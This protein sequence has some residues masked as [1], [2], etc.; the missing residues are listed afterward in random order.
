MKFSDLRWIKFQSTRPSRDGTAVKAVYNKVVSKF[1][2]TRPS[3]DGTH[4]PLY[5]V[6][7]LIFQSTRPS[8]DGT[9]MADISMRAKLNFNPPAPRGTGP[10]RRSEGAGGL[11]ISIH[12]PL[13]GRDVT[14]LDDDLCATYE[15][16]S[17]RPSRDGTS[18]L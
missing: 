13:A 10:R 15:F 5:V 11:Q 1:Q 8:R 17:T 4:G 3:R 2:S 9:H 14:T 12:P 18:C 6:A 7:H 16:Q